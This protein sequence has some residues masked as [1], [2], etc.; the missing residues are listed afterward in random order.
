MDT[1]DTPSTPPEATP[2]AKML[3]LIKRRPTTSRE[4]L[5][6]H[7]FAN[8]MPAVIKGQQ[9]QAAQGK[10]HARRYIA[11][12]Y[13][14]NEK[15]EHPWDG[16]AQLWWDRPLPRPEVPHGEPP[17]DTFQQK[18]E[19]YV[20]WPTTEYVVMDGSDYLKVE[21]LTLNAP[22]PCTRSGFYKISFLVAAKEGT[23]FDKF[24]AHWLA[25]HVPNVRSVMEEVGGFGYVVSHSMEPEA[26]PYAGLAELYFHDEAGW[27]AYGRTITG[28][29]MEE[30]VDPKRMHVLGGRTEMIG[31]P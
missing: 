6:A 21:P 2:G 11:T 16:M 18:V 26:E 30:W 7:W 28:D 31:L 4:E 17:M 24:Y 15:G 10:L 14:A 19:P 27:A 8:H 23:D 20:P 9:D 5:V 1:P 22:F 25:T 12:L 13:D 3:Y 29:G